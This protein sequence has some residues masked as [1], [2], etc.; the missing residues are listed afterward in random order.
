MPVL[1]PDTKD[2]NVLFYKLLHLIPFKPVFL[3]SSC[4]TSWST[5]CSISTLLNPPSLH[6][7]ISR[8]NM[9]HISSGLSNLL[10]PS[11]TLLKVST[12]FMTDID[13]NIRHTGHFLII[14]TI[15]HS[16]RYFFPPCPYWWPVCCLCIIKRHTPPIHDYLHHD[17]YNIH[18]EVLQ[19]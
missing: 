10:H 11:T 3:Y 2:T 9:L 13:T 6:I 8:F 17:W 7:N 4:N 16:N 14:F 15:S 18:Q 5:S 19:N 1:L 12:P